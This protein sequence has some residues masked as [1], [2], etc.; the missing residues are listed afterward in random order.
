MIHA[1]LNSI[2]DDVT[3]ECEWPCF[4]VS[5]KAG[6]YIFS[7]YFHKDVNGDS[8]ELAQLRTLLGVESNESLVGLK[9]VFDTN[10][11]GRE[12][13]PPRLSGS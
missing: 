11:S 10:E 9:V 4:R 12:I 3:N 13:W 2:W 6:D 7:R 5:F 1:T 8:K